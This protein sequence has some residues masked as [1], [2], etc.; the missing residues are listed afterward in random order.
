MNFKGLVRVAKKTGHLVFGD[1]V[2][3]IMIRGKTG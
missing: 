1:M 2:L 3:P